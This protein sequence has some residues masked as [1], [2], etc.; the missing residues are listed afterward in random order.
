[1]TPKSGDG[2]EGAEGDTSLPLI[3]DPAR[4]ALIGLL[5]VLAFLMLPALPVFLVAGLVYWLVRSRRRPRSPD[6][7][8]EFT[9]RFQR[10]E[11][12]ILDDAEV[13]DQGEP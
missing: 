5:A 1:M 9:N 7:D 12:S 4:G 10:L 6:I 3:A 11:S 2:P 13:S 8:P